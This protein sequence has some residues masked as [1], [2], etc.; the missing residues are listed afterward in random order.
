M[1]T[2]EIAFI[3]GGQLGKMLIQA[4]SIWGINCHVMDKDPH[5]PAAPLA[6]SFTQGDPLSYDDVLEFGKRFKY[7]C[8]ELELVN[9][10][11]L[12]ELQKLGVQIF[13][14][15]AA[16]KIIQDKGWQKQHFESHNIP[17][18]RFELFDT[19]DEIK[20]AVESG[21]WSLPV[22]QK[23]RRFGYDGRGV[24][25]IR[26][27]SDLSD[28]LEGPSLLE[29]LVPIEKEISVMVARNLAGEVVVFP[30]VE[31][32]FDPDANLVKYLTCP[33]SIESRTEQEARDMALKI[34][35][36]FDLKGLLAVELFLD[37]QAKIWVN[38]VA[39]R[40]HNSG[41][42]SIEALA[43]SQFEQLIRCICDIPLGSIEM[44]SPAVMANIIGNAAGAP[45]YAGLENCLEIPGVHV[46]LYG[47]AESRA[48]RKMGHATIMH[49]D[50]KEAMKIAEFVQQTLKVIG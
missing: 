15:P 4:A 43:T 28:L 37:K 45:N 10:E 46:H 29:E 8:L 22:V 35:E 26:D 23:T 9:I 50:L 17:T 47:K 21:S 6:Q 34:I 33:A 25:I 20:S 42:H 30:S 11:A 31:M 36:S 24:K 40:P 38:E 41:H 13:P 16:L 7:L 39:P 44:R 48:N 12:E 27:N 19:P 18:S 5:S 14:D 2:Q 49:S 32:I 1:K 3:A